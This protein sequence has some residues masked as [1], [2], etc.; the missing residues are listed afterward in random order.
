M[1][2]YLSYMM[3]QSHQQDLHR[4]AVSA[5]AHDQLPSR[6]SAIK[7]LFTGLAASRSRQ[8][9][10]TVTTAGTTPHVEPKSA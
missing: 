10:T 8:V 1:H 3:A 2:S 5:R 6:P 9:T 7:R 4:A